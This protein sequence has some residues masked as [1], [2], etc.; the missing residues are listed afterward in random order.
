MASFNGVQN[1]FRGLA[2][3]PGTNLPYVL[4]PR[5]EKGEKGDTGPQGPPGQD[6]GSTAILTT[7]GDLLS[8]D[9]TEAVRLPVG[10][11]GTVLTAN[12][13]TP[14]GLSY[15][16]P[17]AELQ[18]YGVTLG[19]QTGANMTAGDNTVLAGDGAM[20]GLTSAT[21]S[22]IA[23]PASTSDSATV[24]GTLIL[25]PLTSTNAGVSQTYDSNAAY[26][27]NIA[28]NPQLNGVGVTIDPLTNRMGITPSSLQFKENVVTL[29]STVAQSQIAAMR[30][31]TY[32]LVESARTEYGF[33]AEE[34]V[35]INPS[36]VVFGPADGEPQPYA[37]NYDKIVPLLTSEIQRLVAL[38]AAQDTEIAN[39]A[40][41]VNSFQA[42]LNDI[43]VTNNVQNAALDTIRGVDDSQ[44]L[45]LSDLETRVSNLEAQSVQF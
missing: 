32:N 1:G 34:M 19:S 42:Q 6:A 38:N 36:A 9:G 7:Q 10:A 37:I 28:D 20:A 16:L 30:P 35:Q 26:I 11:D 4:V 33:I 43:I 13:A 21:G 45:Q 14:T 23:A 12:S 39:L 40:A 15:T 3:P 31:V 41:I 18:T 44:N 27:F 17:A 8:H 29:D 25:R 22:I 2:L 24:D 5:G